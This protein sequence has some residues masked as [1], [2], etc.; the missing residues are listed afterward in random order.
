MKL[1]GLGYIGFHAPDPAAWLS[2]GTGVLG[3][4]PAR[5]VPGEPV[6]IAAEASGGTASG[7]KGV[8]P[9]GSV[10]LKMDDRQWRI[11]IHPGDPRRVAYMGFEVA[12]G[13]ALAQAVDEVAKAGVKVRMGTPQELVARG[14]QG[15][16]WCS[17]P[18]GNRVELFHA[19][20][21]D[22]GFVSPQGAAFLTGELGL[23]HALLLVADMDAML[24]FYR[25]A[26]G[27]ERSDFITLAPG[28]TLQFLR[29]TRRH[30]SVGLAHF[31]PFDGVHHLMLE[32]QTID[33]VGAA[34]DRASAAGVAITTTL[35]R[36]VNDRMVSFYMRGPSGFDV[37][38]GFDGVLV[39]DSWVDRE[40][41]GPEPW[42]HKGI[43]VEG[44][45][46][47][48]KALA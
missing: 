28:K 47:F 1:Y 25:D 21:H 5:S 20:V 3:M 29:C 34:L 22:L 42:G 6:G 43:S 41:A 45:E 17:D 24:G 12:D 32:M 13:A 10:Y 9:D 27:F 14:V 18:A 44:L 8:A 26:L 2:F 19:A 33:H 46:A 15:L 16:A 4:L 39:D 30:H 36:H 38:V 31:G 48:G 35:G 37:E 23:G 7:G 11:A 40:V